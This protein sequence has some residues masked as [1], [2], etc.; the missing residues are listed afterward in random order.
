MKKLLPC[1]LAAMALSGNSLAVTFNVTRTDD[2]TPDGCSENDCSLREAVIDA[3]ATLEPDTI[4]LPAGTYLIDLDGSDTSEETGDL[5]I[6]SDMEFVGAPSIIDG[7]SLGR[8]MDITGSADVTLRDLTLQNANTSLDTNGTLNGGAIEANG[9]SLRLFNVSLLDNSAQGLGG[10]LRLFDSSLVEIDGC[11]FSG[12]HAGSGAAIHAD[13]G[14]IVRDTI[15]EN[16][17]SD[18][19]ALGSGPVA[20]LAGTTSDSQFERVRFEGNIANGSAGA[21]WFT[22]RGLVIDVLVAKNNE[23]AGGSGGVLFVPGTAHL[24]DVHV[25]NARFSENMAEQGGAIATS[26]DDDTI[27]IRHSGFVNNQATELGG[28]AL[29]VTGG[30]V[31]VI[32]VTFSGNQASA[33][34]GAVYQFGGDL[35]LHHA[36]LAE[37]T[38]SA[39]DAIY[40]LGTANIGVIELANNVLDGAC[41][42]SDPVSVTSLGGN[43]EGPGD[44]CELGAGSDLVGQADMQLG[45]QPLRVNYHATPT[46]EL[47]PGSVARGQGEPAVCMDVE[48]DQLFL[49]REMCNSGAVESEQI[50]RDSLESSDFEI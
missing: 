6:T 15:F 49:D 2:P 19:N 39:G 40:V 35:K 27:D 33:N 47:L 11:L 14:I 43:V 3:D 22:G 30:M 38:A 10:A 31:D 12:N 41:Q 36:T 1:L 21:I 26:D 5:D 17:L 7:Q 18:Q 9:D 44:S 13:I 34:G 32:N 37:N 29:Y 46:H 48:V 25:T 8:I 28:G 23:A 42:V 4:M 45:L 20:Y 24:K 50:F 16:N